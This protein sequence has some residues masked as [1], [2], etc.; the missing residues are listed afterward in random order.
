MAQRR[1]AQLQQQQQN[2]AMQARAD[3][4]NEKMTIARSA[5]MSRLGD[6]GNAAAGRWGDVPFPSASETG[7]SSPS[8]S[9]AAAASTPGAG[10]VPFYG[11]WGGQSALEASSVCAELMQ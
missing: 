5:A 10:F 11:E 3:A 9:P 7:G 2:E 4:V 1:A 6:G 8:F